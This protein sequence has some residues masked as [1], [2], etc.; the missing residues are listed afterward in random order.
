VTKSTTSK[1]YD[2]LRELLIEARKD[3]G[4]TQV[5]VADRLGRTQAYISRY[6]NGS[7]RLDVIEFFEIAEVI[8]FNPLVLL[9]KLYA[10]WPN[11]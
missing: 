9:R 11:R 10:A 5:D 7:R 6:E 4:L 2:L 3:A 8:G 1:K